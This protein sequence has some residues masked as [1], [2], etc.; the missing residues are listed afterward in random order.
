MEMGE[1][2][3]GGRWWGWTSP[4]RAWQNRCVMGRS[5]RLGTVPA[6]AEALTT[7]KPVAW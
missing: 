3:R 7:G 4:D 5:D 1:V 2:R 6:D